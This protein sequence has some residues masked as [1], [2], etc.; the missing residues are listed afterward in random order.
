LLYEHLQAKTRYVSVQLGIGSWQPFDPSYVYQRGYGDC[1]ALSNY[2]IAM[3]Q[4]VGVEAYPV[5]VRNGMDEPE[6]IANFPS[7][8]FNHVIAC[9]PLPRDTLWL[10]CTSQTVPFAHIGAGNEDRH[11]LLVTPDGGKLVRTPRSQSTDNQQIRRATVIL[12]ETGN[13]TAEIHTRYT[14]NQQDRVREA[15]AQSS[16]RE[17]EDW[18]REEIDVP[19]FQLSAADFSK[20]ENKSAEVTLPIKLALPRLASRSGTR[21]FLRPNL[22]ER[23]K[24]VPPEMK[25]RKQ[26]VD[27]S[28]AFMDSDTI[29]FR[30][31]AN[32]TIE[33]GPTPVALETSFGR[34]QSS[35]TLRD[36]TLEYLRRLEMRASRLPATQY[37]AYRQFINDVVKADHAQ[38]V[39]VRKAN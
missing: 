11:V 15:L 9:V 6:V 2:M 27:L 31:P 19:S 5:L 30:L 12:D 8:Q 22:M 29:S 25:E 23:W 1:K 10:E 34:Y 3:L 39:L 20:V 16:P 28:Y 35:V 36:G 26:P 17:R 18:L 32:F 7:N 13:A 37:E 4:A 38:I 33:A 14:G 21:L 24:R